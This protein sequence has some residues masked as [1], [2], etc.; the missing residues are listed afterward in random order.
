MEMDNDDLRAITALRFDIDTSE[1]SI[2][3]EMIDIAINAIGL[4]AITPDEQALGV[5]LLA[6]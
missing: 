5:K 4:S 6:R 1:E 2:P 3:T